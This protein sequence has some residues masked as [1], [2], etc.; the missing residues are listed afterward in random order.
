MPTE[1]TPTRSRPRSTSSVRIN[2]QFFARPLLDE[3][4][5]EQ[6]LEQ[7]SIEHQIAQLFEAAGR[8][9][10]QLGDRTSSKSLQF[11]REKTLQ[12]FLRE[13][14]TLR[15]PYRDIR[16]TTP[17]LVRQVAEAWL[18][19][20]VARATVRTRISHLN[21]L[22]QALGKFE[23]VNGT[24]VFEGWSALHNRS[25]APQV[26][27]STPEKE[28]SLESIEA[29]LSE[30]S[31][32]D[33]IA[34]LQ[35]KLMFHLEVSPRHVLAL[36]PQRASLGVEAGATFSHGGRSNPALF[37]K[38]SATGV[39]LMKEAVAA[40]GTFDEDH[41]RHPGQRPA[42]ARQHLY[43]IASKVGL[44][45]TDLGVTP[46]R[47]AAAHARLRHAGAIVEPSAD[48]ATS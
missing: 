47:L 18:R 23:L 30:A 27:A 19:K 26:R 3:K 43:Y 29:A 46:R 2:A 12:H 15:L 42:A 48:S 35:L 44:T 24:A 21:W 31:N 36:R 13:V 37:V 5:L 4:K 41:L 22:L 8:R 33:R 7:R 28:A 38:L 34:G 17:H 14:A 20:S 25:T 11:A 10:I 6:V 45:E 1:S 39:A 32:L 40:S 9:S 16:S